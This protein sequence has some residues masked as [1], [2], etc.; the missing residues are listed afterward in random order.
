MTSDWSSRRDYIE[1]DVKDNV[2][3]SAG[4]YRLIYPGAK[5]KYYVF[6]VGQ[7][8]DLRAR[9]L[10]HLGASEENACIKRHLRDHSCLYRVAYV[11]R[12]ED[13]DS[14]EKGNIDEYDP[15]CNKK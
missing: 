14:E 8:K 12:Q 15:D 10:Q 6:Y 7:A 13:R 9:L 1:R 11:P 5:G 3:E 2:S 4:V